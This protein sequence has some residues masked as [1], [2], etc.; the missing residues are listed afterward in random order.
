MSDSHQGCIYL[1][2]NSE[3]TVLSLNIITMNVTVFFFKTSFSNVGKS[4]YSSLLC[5]DPSEI[6]LMQYADLLSMLEA[7]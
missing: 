1:I 6:I 7:V 4:N 2:K 5:H 3:K